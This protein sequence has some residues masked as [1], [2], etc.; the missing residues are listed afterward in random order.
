MEKTESLDFYVE[1]KN[2]TGSQQSSDAFER[3]AVQGKENALRKFVPHRP[4][5]NLD[6]PIENVRNVKKQCSEHTNRVR[7]R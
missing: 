1:M 4:T 3:G 6:A 2:K 5:T 7:V